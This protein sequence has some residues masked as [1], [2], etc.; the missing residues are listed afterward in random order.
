MKK[1]KNAH[2]KGPPHG[3][4]TFAVCVF[5]AVRWPSL[6]RACFFAVRW[7]RSLPCLFSLPCV[8]LLLCRALI[9]AVRSMAHLPCPVALPCIILLPHGKDIFAVCWRTA[10]FVGTAKNIFP[11][12]KNGYR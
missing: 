12:V 6:C 10:V 11:V 5:F 4:G 3:K 2:G 1:N 8:L 9:F 7:L